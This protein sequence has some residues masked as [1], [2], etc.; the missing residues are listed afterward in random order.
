M[1]PAFAIAGVAAPLAVFAYLVATPSADRELA[2]PVE[3]LVITTNVAILAFC[4]GVLV[5]RSAV[6]LKQYRTLLVALGFGSIGGI[7]AVHGLATPGVLLRGDANDALAVVALSAQLALLIPAILFAVRYTSAIDRLERL[8]PAR[9]LVA[10]VVGGTVAYAAVA[11]VVPAAIGGLMRAVLPSATGGFGGYA[12]N[13]TNNGL[14]NADVVILLPGGL[15]ILLF[16]FSALRQG[17]EFLRSKLPLQGALVASYLLLAE[18]QVAMTLG[19]LWTLAWWEY[20]GLMLA[21]IAIALVALF[22]E[23]DRRRGLERFLPPNVVERVIQG[24]ALRLEGERRVVTV[25][26]SDL[27][28]ST[29]LADALDPASVV[30]IVNTYLRAMARA[31]VDRGGIIDKFTGDGL[32]A[33]FGAMSDT[34][35]GARAAAGAALDMRA[36]IAALNAERA[37]RGAPVLKHGVG[38]HVGEVV[39]GAIGLPERSDYTAMGDTV[40]LAS[41]MESLC[42]EYGVDAVL[43]ADIAT[44]LDGAVALRALGEARVKGKP[45]P[46]TVFTLA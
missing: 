29:A 15:A 33:I 8:V 26:F 32:M 27:R 18:T 10:L 2:S 13:A 4:S 25:A 37:A 3:H 14:G 41:R 39:L 42:K 34:R 20:H 7:F 44:H 40:N 6:Q 12:G 31:V 28:G 36:G 45:E 22:I 1:R 17:R 11:L 46:I 24:D 43:S 35:A 38:L 23:L 19:Q 16:A 5:A 30:A 9:A 21:A